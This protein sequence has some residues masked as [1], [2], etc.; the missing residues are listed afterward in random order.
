MQ[1]LILVLLI[2][3]ITAIIVSHKALAG[4][5]RVD[6]I[7]VDDI[8]KT[9]DEVYENVDPTGAEYQIDRFIK[10]CLGSSGVC[11]DL[12]L[13]D[14]ACVHDLMYYLN[15]FLAH[16]KSLQE[17]EAEWDAANAAELEA[18]EAEAEAEIDQYLDDLREEVKDWVEGED[19]ISPRIEVKIMSY[20]LFKHRLSFN[21]EARMAEPEFPNGVGGTGRAVYETRSP[22]AGGDLYP[23]N[24]MLGGGGGA[25]GGAVD[26]YLLDKY[27]DK[28]V[29]NYGE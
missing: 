14:T 17:L 5:V 24:Y 28:E 29:V 6:V 10:E 27:Y 8:D 20:I 19:Y 4:D 23:P 7:T 26:A 12:D 13:C 9:I 1:K 3:M 21:M 16:P 11:D 2:S 18:I 25:G 22:M 15:Q